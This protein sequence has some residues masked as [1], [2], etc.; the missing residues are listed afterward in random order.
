MGDTG[1]VHDLS[2]H[3]ED[4]R[5]RVVVLSLDETR[6]A[7]YMAFPFYMRKIPKRVASMG[8][9]RE[10]LSARPSTVRE[11]AGSMTPSSQR[12]ALEKYGWPSFSYFSRVGFLNASSSSTLHC[13]RC[14]YEEKGRQPKAMG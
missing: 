8:A 14:R 1:A 13:N 10:A 4:A 11:S 6:H 5:A 7:H 12:R 2:L 3:T 9:L